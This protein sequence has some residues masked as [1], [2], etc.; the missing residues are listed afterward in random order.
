MVIFA[1]TLVTSFSESKT[2]FKAVCLG[3]EDTTA[4]HSA[5]LITGIQ[6][7]RTALIYT[8]YK[9]R[10]VSDSAVKKCF[11]PFL[12]CVCFDCFLHICRNDSDNQTNLYRLDR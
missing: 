12:F 10:C 8:A 1:V 7:E 11:P 4:E 6:A 2:C 9:L 3:S 5:G